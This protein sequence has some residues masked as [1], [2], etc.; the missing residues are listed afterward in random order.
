[1]TNSARTI[2]A[3]ARM[4]LLRWSRSRTPLGLLALAGLL[5]WYDN[6]TR[7]AQGQGSWWSVGM[8]LAAWTG[9]LLG[10]DGF[11][12]LRA[13]GSLRQLLIRPLGVGALPLSFLTAGTVLGGAVLAVAVGAA[14][15]TGQLQMT[16]SLLPASAIMFLGFLAFLAYAQA[17]SA[18][19]PR[20][21]AAVLVVLAVVLGSGPPERWIPH[22]CPEV[23]RALIVSAWVAMP[24][25]YRLAE[26]TAGSDVLVNALL[27]LSYVAVGAAVAS[28][29]LMRGKLV[30]RMDAT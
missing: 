6:A 25:T 3:L 7:V 19:L 8:T 29:A 11:E 22:G 5:L 30:R 16:A 24:T 14:L 4:F 26:T 1:M 23:V 20:D 18:L 12:R 27:L 21:T 15:L 9:A 13:E 2:A 10:Y 17:V 28:L